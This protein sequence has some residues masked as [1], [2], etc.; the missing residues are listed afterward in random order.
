MSLIS[1]WAKKNRKLLYEKLLTHEEI[2]K[3]T[4]DD[5]EQSIAEKIWDV[6]CCEYYKEN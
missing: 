5:I 6:I 4:N 3:T 2:A 1:E